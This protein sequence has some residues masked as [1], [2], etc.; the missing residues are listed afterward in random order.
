MKTQPETPLRNILPPFA[1]SRSRALTLARSLWILLAAALAAMIFFSI[2]T[3]AAFPAPSFPA[4][5]LTTLQQI[6]VQPSGYAIL[7]GAL[8]LIVALAFFAAALVIFWSKRADRMALLVSAA[9]LTFGATVFPVIAIPALQGIVRLIQIL[10]IAAAGL[11]IFLFPNGR[12]FPSWT[13]PLALFLGVWLTALLVFPEVTTAGSLASL[14][15]MRVVVQVLA[16]LLG[17]DVTAEAFARALQAIRTVGFVSMMV[18]GFGAGAAA[19]VYRYFH[20][21]DPAERQQTKLVVFSLAVA[22]F[23]SLAYY[24]PPVFLSPLS[25]SGP[26]RLIFQTAGQLVFSITLILI[27]LFLMIAVLRYRLWDADVLINRTLV[28]LLLTGLLAGVYFISI[29]FFQALVRAVTG[30]GSDWVLVGSTLIIAA[31]FRPLR[32]RLQIFI[33]RRFYREKVD[34]RRVF[35][36][37]GRELRTLIELPELQQTL[38]DRVTELLHIRYAAI[39]LRGLESPFHPGYTVRIPSGAN[40]ELD[41]HPE[42]LRRLESGGI[43]S[44]PA[45]PSFPLLVPLTSPQPDG[46]TLVGILALGPRLSGEGYSR[47]DQSLLLG[48]AEQAGTSIRVAQL[49]D[50]KQ[51]ETRQRLEAEKQLADHRSSPLG[52]AEAT[53]SR[54]L[55]HPDLA[56]REFHRLAQESGHDPEAAE[57]AAHLPS[58]LKS[59][60]ADDLARLAEGYAYLLEGHASS[61]VLPVALRIILAALDSQ[62]R[63]GRPLVGAAE[64]LAAYSACLNALAAD[65]VSDIAGWKSGAGFQGT[66]RNDLPR[67]E[68]DFPADLEELLVELGGISDSLHAIERLDAAQDKL[69][70]LAAAV[71]RLKQLDVAARGTLGSA[72]RPIGCGM[73]ARWTG[74]LRAAMDELKSRAQIVC[75]LL[76]RHLWNADEITLVLFLRNTGRGTAQN[77]ELRPMP[78]PEYEILDGACGVGVL[79]PGEETR[80]EVRL[81]PRTAPDQRRFRALFEIHYADPR[82]EDQCESFADSI[83]LLEPAGKFTHIPNPYVVGIPLS[84]GSPMFFGRED[85]MTFLLEQLAAAHRN[86]LVL[87]GPRRTG[88]SSLLKQLPLRLGGDFLPVY[89]DGQSLALDPGLPAFLHAV[90]C[91]ISLAMEARG[92]TVPAPELSAFAINPTAEFERVFLSAVRRQLGECHLLLLLDEFEELESAARRGTLDAAIFPFLRHLMQHAQNLSVIFCGTHRLE[93]LASD[94]WSVLFNISLYRRIGFLS[95]EEAIRLIQDP[96]AEYGMRCDDLAL[97]KIW[98]VTA[99]HPYFLQLICHSLVNRHNRQQRSYVTVADVNAAV[100]EILTTGEAHFVYL[101]LDSTRDQKLALYAMSRLGGAGSLTPKQAADELHRQGISVDAD[102]LGGAF[103]DLAARDIFTAHQRSD[104]PFGGAYAWKLGLLG[105]WVETSR[106][107]DRIL[108]EEKNPGLKSVPSS[109]D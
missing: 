20:T 16:W 68:I 47:E 25:E 89:L 58:A 9:L 95:R 99:G 63:S 22:V 96:V 8:E 106:S 91:E 56:L 44:R 24:L 31:L 105:L 101:W 77:L 19:Q 51:T 74:V 4:I 69:G 104:P 21:P 84:A 100:E 41:L 67:A 60:G 45:A 86:N 62:L 50:E 49:I 33:D 35:T 23:A 108:A 80:A 61:E 98:R 26:A 32:D 13:R 42:E 94:Y 82:G 15:P 3:R 17:T 107:L 65:S 29:Y 34:F 53:A 55:A 6:G 40:A 57:L 18:G 7:R 36:E 73:T 38:V 66:D 88:K 79:S 54:I 14:N 27:P 81:G 10:G 1:R 5:E 90:A 52:R 72:D 12:F 103:R 109:V 48:L 30:Q 75:G 2:W 85:V 46:G 93:E 43:I 39:F 92:W 37:F 71:E 70:Y 59:A 11:T 64:A 28:Y 97:E 87:I 83:E 76:T 102:A 78:S